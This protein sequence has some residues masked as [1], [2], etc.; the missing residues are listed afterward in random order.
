M[1]VVT[2]IHWELTGS[3]LRLASRQRHSARPGGE[4][5][6]GIFP[7]C[8]Q[9]SFRGSYI[10]SRNWV[11][12]AYLSKAGAKKTTGRH[13][14][15]GFC[16]LCG[17]GN[18]V[19]ISSPKIGEKRDESGTEA[20][21]VR[22]KSGCNESGLRMG[23]RIGREATRSGGGIQG[24]KRLGWN[25]DEKKQV[26]IAG[27]RRSRRPGSQRRVAGGAMAFGS[28]NGCRSA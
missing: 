17:T 16:D 21:C 9:Y 2:D 26:Q 18:I 11:M 4:G 24:R 19:E 5:S 8:S 14:G 22:D 12:R 23:L 28:R 25:D 3:K 15:W 1:N 27:G 7:T 10:I 6:Q 20:T 13:R